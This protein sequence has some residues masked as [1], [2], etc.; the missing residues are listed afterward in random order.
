MTI[1]K[2]NSFKRIIS[3]ILAVLCVLPLSLLTAF[4]DGIATQKSD[5]Y[6]GMINSPYFAY[7]PAKNLMD[8]SSINGT[9]GTGSGVLKYYQQSG[10][11]I[12]LY[13]VEP[14]KVLK[15]G[16]NL[17]LNN[18]IRSKT[19]TALTEK[20]D[21]SKMLGRLFLYAY[22]GEASDLV[23]PLSQYMATQILVWEITV[24][25][26]DLFFNHVSNSNGGEVLD[27]LNGM[28]ATV[29]NKIMGYYNNYV[30][31]MKN[32]LKIPS[33][34]NL[35]EN[36]AQEYVVGR[37][38]EVVLT[39][40]NN[41]LSNF[42]FTTT[43]GSINISGNSLVVTVPA[44]SQAAITAS[45][46]V[47]SNKRAMFCYGTASY[48]NVVAVG[49]LEIDPRNSFVKI[50]GLEKG[51]LEI[52]K[53]SEDGIVSGVEFNINGNG[54]DTTVKTDANGI[55][56]IPELTAGNYTV[57]EVVPVRYENQQSRIVTVN[58]GKTATVSFANVLRKGTIK[59]NKQAEDG[60]VGAREFIISGDGKIYTASTDKNGIAVLT[61][62]PV[63]N[64][65]NQEI[66]YTI[67]EKNVPIRYVIPVN[68][69]TS[70]TADFTTM[71]TFSNILKKFKVTVTKVDS[72]T[73]TSQGDARLQGAVY[74]IYKG[75]KLID[76]YI[77]DTNG[78]FTTSEYICCD[79]W[80]IK[81]IKAS[82][83]YLVDS[84]SYHV[85]A[86]PML[87]TVEHST[88]SNTVSENIIKGK[89]S[90]IKH[91][92]DGSTG[93]EHPEVNAEFQVYLKSSGSYENAKPSERDYLIT[94]EYGFAQT[95]SLP[96]GTYTVHQAKGK[97]STEYISD[98]TVFVNEDGKSY[99]F[100]LNNATM[101]SLVQIVKKDK[102][103]GKV[104]AA[105][106]IG[107]RIKNTT[108]GKF[109]SQHINY[110]TP[111]DIDTFYTDN[112][113]KLV[114]PQPLVFGKYELFEISAP[115]G[116]ALDSEPIP[117]TVDGTESVISVE[118]SDI[119]QKGTIT[120]SKKGEIFS[121]VNKIGYL[122][123]PIYENKGLAGAVFNI[124]A[125]EDIYTLDGT[126]RAKTGEVVDTVTTDIGGKAISKQL[127]LGKYEIVEEKAPYGFV[128]NKQGKYA[129]LL[130]A[131]QE[132]EVAEA[133]NLNFVSDRQKVEIS[134][135]KALEQDNLF[136][137]GSNAEY[138]NILFGLYADED[139]T[140]DDATVIP[141]DRLI[142]TA[143]LS[144]DMTAVF[145]ADI[146]FGKYYVREISTD[147]HYILN[148][149]KYLVS[150]EY[151][152][153]EI[154]TKYLKANNGNS[155]EN[156]IKRGNIEG[157]KI[158]AQTKEGLKNAIIG[159]FKVGTTEYTKANALQTAI[160]DENGC[161][162]F[163]DIPFGEYVIQEISAP[164]GYLLSNKIY[165]VSIKGQDN[166]VNIEIVNNKEP[167]PDIP[168]ERNPKTSDTNSVV[169]MVI[170]CAIA[171]TSVVVLSKKKKIDMEE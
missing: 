146:S 13:C 117:F 76:T 82:E 24:G 56:N 44:G 156:Y 125:S 97:P 105:S 86:E 127:Y 91:N 8:T 94:D 141:K 66:N 10:R 72:Q 170:L 87:Y 23:E 53:T 62:I 3:L 15:T 113:G 161:F 33:F 12:P 150:F 101:V 128:I 35:K 77:T 104:I 40:T 160:S 163:A 89:I 48:Q 148:G 103:T 7:G 39:D 171:F 69:T 93:I 60:Y 78:Q 26:R 153:Q 37:D 2:K 154:S 151:Q 120:I 9:L 75:N 57:T 155:I 139:I 21:I 147:E 81:E 132:I 63:F 111:M 34:C 31:Q 50:K 133:L 114:L 42:N 95:K 52:I 116:Y 19:N 112:T 70:I 16:N 124:T 5:I 41:V 126:L 118:K 46:T 142:A 99:K 137:I 79:D 121:S 32:H 20:E 28:N 88:T 58:P 11:L 100:L 145:N 73:S 96:F 61:N 47:N 27:I 18:Y 59:I 129:E 134:L 84:T 14:G 51:T 164:I 67:S 157:K 65:N 149:E 166:I 43:S 110:P 158:D 106:G 80:T 55:I 49:A 119:A 4:A 30:L 162:S 90:I 138:K 83:G 92:D 102:E 107:F 140:A 45:K 64:S 115:Q 109:I 85:G 22:T 135:K 17:D 1:T 98:Y 143:S 74:G 131:G 108:T 130:Y 6:V 122:Y 36:S 144:D 71:L 168:L 152:G 54:V 159:L 68:Q 169:L 123:Q 38:G 167:I 29:A 165:P 25:E 136:E